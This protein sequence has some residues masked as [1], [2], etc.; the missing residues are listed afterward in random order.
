MPDATRK[1]VCF[2]PRSASGRK[3]LGEFTQISWNEVLEI[4]AGR[5]T[6]ILETTGGASVVQ[7]HCTGTFAH[8]G[9]GFPLR[10]FYKT[11][12]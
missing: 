3:E 9:Y 2:I 10:F 12:A 4:V 7:T 5:L 8:I 1:R 11:G 6:A